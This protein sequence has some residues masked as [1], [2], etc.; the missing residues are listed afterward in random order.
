MTRVLLVPALILAI[1]VCGARAQNADPVK[2]SD[3]Q[4]ADALG[5]RLGPVP[6]FLYAHVPHLKRGEGAVIEHIKPNSAADQAGLRRHDILQSYGRQSIRNADHFCQLVRAG[7]REQP[8]AL[9]L[10][11]DGKEMTLQVTLAQPSTPAAAVVATPSRG[12]IKPGGPPAVNIE[13]QRLEGE[14]LQITFTYYSPGTGKLERVTCSG[15]LAQI[16]NEV[17]EL[18]KQN[19]MSSRVQDLVDVALR[20]IRALNFPNNE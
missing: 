9:V 8:V 7:T 12:A 18:G 15:S 11:R 10:L 16:E 20:R 2:S 4:D 17:R 1:G 14:R 19:R 13:A 5:L 3:K 6:A